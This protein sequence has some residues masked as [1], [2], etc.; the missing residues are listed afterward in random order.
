MLE[1]VVDAKF[2]LIEVC[3]R[4]NPAP[5]AP[6][7]TPCTRSFAIDANF[8][9]TKDVYQRI[10]FDPAVEKKSIAG[11]YQIE[12]RGKE[13]SG[14]NFGITEF[15]EN[16]VLLAKE[17]KA[18]VPMREHLSKWR[19]VVYFTFELSADEIVKAVHIR[20]SPIR[21]SFLLGVSQGDRKPTLGQKGWISSSNSIMITA[22]DPLFRSKGLYTVGV[23]PKLE[24][25]A[26]EERDYR[27][28]VKWTYTNKHSVLSP[29]VPEF[30]KL[31]H[32]SECFY[33]DILPAWNHVL[34]AKHGQS[35]NLDLFVS[36]GNTHSRPSFEKHHYFALAHQSGF[37]LDRQKIEQHCVTDFSLHR[38]CGA[39]MCLHG[40]KGEEFS[41][42]V[43]P[44]YM[45]ILLGEGRLFMG[46][47]PTTTT[48]LRFLYRPRKD[49]SVDIEEFTTSFAVSV[50]ASLFEEDS[51]IVFP[52]P[53]E[54]EGSLSSSVVHFPHE[55]V[56]RFK[57]PLVAITVA[58]RSNVP[59]TPG[60]GFNFNFWFGL[61]AG[62]LIKELI[63]H[64]PRTASLVK[65]SWQYFY[66]YNTDISATIYVGL[67]SLNSGDADMFISRGKD[68]R[69]TEKR[70]LA[71]SNGFQSTYLRLSKKMMRKKG[72]SNTQGYFV[73]GVKANSDIDF[74]IS[75]KTSA[76]V[77]KQ[78]KFNHQY[79]SIV[80]NDKHL[81]LV[82]FNF[83]NEDFE[84][85]IDT[86]HHEA[87][88]Y[89]NTVQLSDS[90]REN[91]LEL[92]PGPQKFQLRW[93]VERD[94]KTML[95]RIP[96]TAPGFCHACKFYFNIRP[97]R[98]KSRAQFEY[99]LSIAGFSRL[100]HPEVLT[101]GQGTTSLM[102][103]GERRRFKFHFTP[104]QAALLFKSTLQMVVSSG[105]GE[106][107][108]GSNESFNSEK[109]LLKH[110]FTKGHNSLSLAPLKKENF[111]DLFLQTDCKDLFCSLDLNLIEPGKLIALRKNSPYEYIADPRMPQSTF[112]Y[113]LLGKERFLQIRFQIEEFLDDER[114]HF[115]KD[116]L[117]KL[118]RVYFTE[119]KQGLE[120]VNNTALSAQLIEADSI[121]NELVYEYRP[122]K[123]FYLIHV[124]P[125]A[126][127]TFKYS[128]EVNTEHVTG[129]VSGRPTVGYIGPKSLDHVFEFAAQSP[130]GIYLRYGLC[131][132]GAQTV[133][134]KTEN[135]KDYETVSVDGSRYTQ[136]LDSDQESLRVYV[137]VQKVD[138]FSSTANDFGF[139]DKQKRAAVFSL[140]MVEREKYDRIP[141]DKIRP[142]A[143]ELFVDLTGDSPAVYFRP[144]VFPEGEADKYD[145][146]YT[147][148]VS[149]DPDVV[150]Y[151]LNCQGNM[152]QKVLKKGFTLKEAVQTFSTEFNP[153]PTKE[154]TSDN[155]YLS[156]SPKLSSGNK[157]FINLYAQVFLKKTYK[158][159]NYVDWVRNVV[160][161]KYKGLDFEYRSFF[162]PIE[163]LAATL[164]LVA[165]IFGSCCIFDWDLKRC[166]KKKANY[167]GIKNSVDAEL[168]DY[169][170]KIKYE[171]ERRQNKQKSQQTRPGKPEAGPTTE[172][173]SAASDVTAEEPEGEHNESS[174][175]QEQPQP[176]VLTELKE[177]EKASAGDRQRPQKEDSEEE[178]N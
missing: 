52:V 81:N 60:S 146:V 170:L 136:V 103:K 26:A 20:L 151:Y 115:T 1:F 109:N 35:R 139:L 149:R 68:E 83:F 40:K 93:S 41:L 99:K 6:A 85:Q 116:F 122:K 89:W 82:F 140:E 49:S 76:A 133:L 88:I 43:V 114:R 167:S 94:Q 23:F 65:G 158:K 13:N 135:Q 45:P 44:D 177:S 67:D 71:K 123:G 59:A 22:S 134:A 141:F 77:L 31:I 24:G 100:L 66:L 79:T 55:Q 120:R 131:F 161:I 113:H 171:F 165:V 29:G 9:S 159:G 90:Y 27:F 12:L 75:W 37:E 106:A 138:S 74:S 142:S 3:V 25:G 144:L 117:K 51:R 50:A 10:R 92:V 28:E 152:L 47:P 58:K 34:V 162:Y 63:R 98:V 42:T 164:G 174:L 168:E 153:K 30:G 61:E 126:N 57:K 48:S 91:D 105:A 150:H 8:H 148:V 17:I 128:I 78:I 137:K 64:T 53:S 72:L 56:S 4:L 127:A 95:F 5:D 21:G 172:D 154:L 11:T 110:Q 169:Y 129:L 124:H 97:Q 108:F 111:T 19:E 14:L 84:F 54:V 62:Y 130:G 36:L 121:T 38:K 86:H 125:F 70:Y 147:L 18:G 96:R 160:R 112:L 69:P 73:L 119:D 87:E 178:D 157:Y 166:L 32:Q 107:F 102:K 175:Q 33:F 104:Q 173:Q 176:A 143:E 145:V 118:F 155:S 16:G 2:G 7:S 39:Y 15:E 80:R 163:L 132:G 101:L 46:P 156:L